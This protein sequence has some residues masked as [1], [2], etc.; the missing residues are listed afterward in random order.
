MH[1]VPCGSLT[2]IPRSR[3]ADWSTEGPIDYLHVTLQPKAFDDLLTSEWSGSRTELEFR[4]DV[5]FANPLMS[6]LMIEMLRVAATGEESQLYVDTLFTAFSLVLLRRCSAAKSARACANRTA[7]AGGMAGWRLRRVVDFM[8]VHRGREIGLDELVDVS[9]LSRAHFFRAFSQA[10]GT[11]PARFLT[12]MRLE[13]AR[14][15]IER[16]AE[17]EAAA[18]VAGFSCYAAFSRAFRRA[19]GVTPGAYRRWYR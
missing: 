10:V 6:S 5:G 8:M 15:A 9:G 12:K 1:D 16:G 4:D 19:L 14:T 3:V 7:V 18:A 2:V 13:D 17:L 11:T